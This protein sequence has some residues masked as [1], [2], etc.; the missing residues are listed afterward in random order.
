[1]RSRLH[2][3]RDRES[4]SEE[5]G[6]REERLLQAKHG[7]R[8]RGPVQSS[9]EYQR[10]CQNVTSFPQSSVT[11][12]KKKGRKLVLSD[13]DDDDEEDEEEEEEEEEGESSYV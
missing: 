13:D 4:D 2:E 8:K 6:A 5:E 10:V 11:A 7:E 3:R 9:G 1:M 12:V